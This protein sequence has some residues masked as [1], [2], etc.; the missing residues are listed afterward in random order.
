MINLL[1]NKLLPD[2]YG[3]IQKAYQSR[4]GDLSKEL[5]N[6]QN[7]SHNDSHNESYHV[8]LGSEWLK[9]IIFGGLDGI[10]TIFSIICSGYASN[11]S[12]HTIMILGFA[13]IIAD[14]ISMGHGDY[15]SEKTEQDY[16]K[17]QYSR[18]TWEMENHPNGEIKEMIEIY[19]KKYD[20]SK[21]D[22]YYI[23]SNMANY[24]QLFID[25]MM[26]LELGLMPPDENNEPFKN[27]LITFTSFI[28]FGSIP[29]IVYILTNMIQWAIIST[30]ITL[31]LLGYLRSYFTKTNKL[32]SC[33]ITIINGCISASAAYGVSYAIVYYYPIN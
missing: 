12:I 23:L 15:F 4:N 26:V 29:L 8:I 13:N 31:G 11:L 16:I 20:I 18:E 27:G 14:A 33:F 28:F 25:H 5:H 3:S 6:S 9:S 17:D 22:A 19:Q 30:I 21:E 10:I 2:D 32:Y 24:K 1:N 7:D